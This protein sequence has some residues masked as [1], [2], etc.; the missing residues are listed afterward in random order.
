MQI[1]VKIGT[2]CYVVDCKYGE[3]IDVI[4]IKAFKRFLSKKN[5]CFSKIIKFNSPNIFKMSRFS[6]NNINI[7]F[8]SKERV[9]REMNELTLNHSYIGGVT[10]NFTKDDIDY[11]NKLMS[12]SKL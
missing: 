10:K 8:G 11:I 12:V 6:I 1:F 5:I 2:N 9:S 7:K 3:L 4:I